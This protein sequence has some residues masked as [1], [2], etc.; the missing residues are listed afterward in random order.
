MGE[1]PI[2]HNPSDSKTSE[3]MGLVGHP[4]HVQA[5][6][7]LLLGKSKYTRTRAEADKGSSHQSISQRERRRW[8]LAS[9][10]WRSGGVLEVREGLC[11]TVSD[12]TQRPWRSSAAKAKSGR[13]VKQAHNQ[14][15]APRSLTKKC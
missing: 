8:Q 5:V 13:L 6:H 12:K 10:T 9:K 1:P 3:E 2:P 4:E 15:H 11:P 7:R 14:P